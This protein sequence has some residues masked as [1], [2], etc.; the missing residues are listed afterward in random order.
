MSHT[1]SSNLI[2]CV[3]STKDRRKSIYS[4]LRKRL[5]PYLG[6]IARDNNMKALAVGGTDDHVHML[7]SLPPTV[8]VSKAVQLIK[9]GSSKWIHDTFPA[10]HLFQW[11]E[12]YG[13]FSI[14]IS[15]KDDTIRYIQTQEAHHKTRTFDEEFVSFLQ[16]HAIEY[17]SKYVL[18]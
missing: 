1:Y 11:Q 17:D 14:S 4:Q 13:A 5:W 18:G 12:G 7:I 9:G 6:G 16:T 15:H 2:H 3:F 10:D 8:S